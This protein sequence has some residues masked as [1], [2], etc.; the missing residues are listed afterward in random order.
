M[1]APL[2]ICHI[3]TVH[4]WSDTRIF[5]RMCVSLAARGHDVTLVAPVEGDR[6]EQGVRIIPTRLNGKLKRLVAVPGLLRRLAALRAHIYH[7]H[8]PELLPWMAAFRGAGGARRVVY[9]V[10]EYY[11]ETVV[12]SNYF[13]WRPASLAAG[14]VFGRAEPWLARRLDA[15]V[16]VTEPI[17]QRFRGGPVRV[18][19]IRNMVPLE[20]VPR[21]LEPVALPSSRTVVL[22]GVMDRNRLMQELLQA[23]AAVVSDWP[24]LH[25]LGIGDL[26][27]DPYGDELRRLAQQLGIGDRIAFAPRQPW[28]RLQSYLAQSVA[29][30]VLLADRINF[31]W[32]L[33][34]RLFEF[35]LHGV[36]VIASD[37]PLVREVVESCG[38]G[39]LLDSARP[40]AIAAA[41]R[42]L[43]ADPA[44]ARR[45]GERGRQAVLARY[46]WEAEMDRLEALYRAL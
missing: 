9:D 37:V 4:P 30:M 25:F 5:E 20:R 46:N 18:A 22:A 41:L 24:D 31:R 2:R 28:G 32:S 21:P 29:G 36:P 1:P 10:H 26:L 19:V 35:M 11:A 16:G 23:L 3:T 45:L 14:V 42:R 33:P 6:L 12:D 38:C 13:R 43:L 7:F 8:D 39:I 27:T 15:V 40:E 17:A 44:E 34:T